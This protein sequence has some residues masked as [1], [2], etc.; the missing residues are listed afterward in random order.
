MR[1]AASTFQGLLTREDKLKHYAV[2]RCDREESK[3]QLAG[4]VLSQLA[5][6]LDGR[7]IVAALL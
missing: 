5:V 4:S 2:R 7:E 6:A 3:V 1:Q